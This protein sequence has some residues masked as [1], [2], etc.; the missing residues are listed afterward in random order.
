MQTTKGSSSQSTGS[1]Q[2]T[3]EEDQC[4]SSTC[5]RGKEYTVGNWENNDDVQDAVLHLLFPQQSYENR[6]RS[7]QGANSLYTYLILTP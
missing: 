1:P 3:D 5:T 4:E 6:A 7:N 2:A